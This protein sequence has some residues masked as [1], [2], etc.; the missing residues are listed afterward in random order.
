VGDVTPVATKRGLWFWYTRAS[1]WV[2]YGA[3]M[4]IAA[5][6]PFAESLRETGGV[7]ADLLSGIPIAMSSL[8]GIGGIWLL[9]IA[10]KRIRTGHDGNVY[11]MAGPLGVAWGEPRIALSGYSV[12]H[13]VL[14]W[15]EVQTWHPFVKTING[16]VDERKIIFLLVGEGKVELDLHPF[17]DDPDSV[18]GSIQAAMTVWTEPDQ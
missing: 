15:S 3:V 8:M 13:H 10:V 11:A 9:A 7:K 17:V 2:F 6:M 5:I 16:K 4:L 12:S 14:A 18:A 1:V